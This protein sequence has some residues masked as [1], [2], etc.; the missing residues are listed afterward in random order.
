M[1]PSFCVIVLLLY[2]QVRTSIIYNSI[3]YLEQYCIQ[4]Q[5]LYHISSSMRRKNYKS[6]LVLTTPT[7]RDLLPRTKTHRDT[8]TPRVERALLLLPAAKPTTTP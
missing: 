1:F 2:H 6:N 5:L 3:I 7:S 8:L 4:Q